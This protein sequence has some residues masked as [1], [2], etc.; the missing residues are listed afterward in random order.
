[1]AIVRYGDAGVVLGLTAETTGYVQEF[2]IR[3]LYDEVEVPNEIGETI[4]FGQFN[5]RWEGSYVL[6]NKSGATVPS[7]ATAIAVA[8]CTEA[9][10]VVITEKE[11][12]PEQKGAQ[13][14]TLSFKA[15]ANIT[16]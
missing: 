7:S 3:E 15:W 10:K 1:M 14:Y 6:V 12:K 2:T 5:K 8:N 13:K 4:T 11:R 9:A 16:L